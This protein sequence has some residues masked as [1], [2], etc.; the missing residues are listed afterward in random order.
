M[1]NKENL[2]EKHLLKLKNYRDVCWK[3]ASNALVLGVIIFGFSLIPFGKEGNTGLKYHFMRELIANYSEN[4]NIVASAADNA[5]RSYITDPSQDRF[6]KIEFLFNDSKNK[7]F[8]DYVK[9]ASGDKESIANVAQKLRRDDYN[10]FG[11]KPI[12]YLCNVEQMYDGRVLSQ[13]CVK[14]VDDANVSIIV[15]NIIRMIVAVLFFLSINLFFISDN[16]D[17]RIGGIKNILNS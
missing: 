11:M 9:A 3:I 15:T 8:V 7:P 17:K 13:L 10:G 2:G 1:S 6:N 4:N 16:M 5:V 12:G 14:Y